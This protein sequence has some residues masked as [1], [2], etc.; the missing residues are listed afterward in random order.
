M[1]RLR[2]RN[3]FVLV[4]VVMVT[5]LS[6]VLLVLW[7]S[8]VALAATLIAGGVRLR[9]GPMPDEPRRPPIWHRRRALRA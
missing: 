2:F 5:A 4:A 1:D 8:G 3:H 6:L 7:A 9:H